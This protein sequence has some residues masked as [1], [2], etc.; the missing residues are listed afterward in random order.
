MKTIEITATKAIRVEGIIVKGAKMVN[1]RQMYKRKTD[2]EWQYGRST[3]SID[4]DSIKAVRKAL[5][6]CAEGDKFKK[7]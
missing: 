1:L 4:V 2:E 5:R 3:I 7:L 6:L